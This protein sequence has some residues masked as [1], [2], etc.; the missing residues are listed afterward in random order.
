MDKEMN[1]HGKKKM[2]WEIAELPK[3]K[4]PIRCK[5]V[6]LQKNKADRT[7]KKYKARLETKGNTLDIW[8]G[9]SRNLC[10]NSKDNSVQVL[11]FLA[12]NL[13]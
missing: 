5:Q 4:K 1:S 11:L 3:W 7:L 10:S 13:G 2:T 9:L 6:L 12:A 8:S